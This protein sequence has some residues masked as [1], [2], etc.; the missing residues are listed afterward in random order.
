MN[1]AQRLINEMKYWIDRDGRWASV[2]VTE[3][4]PMVNVYGD[5]IGNLYNIRRKLSHKKIRLTWKNLERYKANSATYLEFWK[6][7]LKSFEGPFNVF[8]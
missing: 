5:L 1:T 7:N 4:E 8:W 6:E 3:D 2:F